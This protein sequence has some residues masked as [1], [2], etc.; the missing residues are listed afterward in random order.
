MC[1]IAGIVSRDGFD[2]QTLIA[3]T[4]MISYR[5]PSG[6]GFAYS[7]HVPESQ[8]EIHYDERLPALNRP[9]IGLG[10]R[11]L[12]ILDLSPSGNQPMQTEDGRYCLTYN[13]EIY[14]YRE[15][16]D[17]LRR[18]G[19]RFNSATDTEVLLRSYAQWGEE[20][21]HRFNGMWSFAL[22]DRAEQTLFCARDR[23]GVKPFY[24]IAKDRQFF[25]ASEIKQ[26]LAAS[27]IERRAN[28]R[29]IADFLEWGLQDHLEETSF[30]GV[31]QL[32]G[33]HSLT[34]HLSGQLRPRIT[35]YWEL[36]VDPELHISRE[37]AVDEFRSRFADAVSLRLR[38]DVPVGVSLSGGLDSSAILCEAKRLS[39]QSTFQA[40]SACFDEPRL[41]ER[42]YISTIL[43]AT[44]SEKHWTFPN[45]QS[46][47]NSLDTI[48]Y[49]QDEPVGGPS[50]F[51]QWRVMQEARANNVP[52]LL[53]GQGG[54]ESLCGYRKYYFFHLWHLLRTANPAFLPESLALARSGTTSHW[55]AGTISR[56]L[57]ATLRKNNSALD[58]LAA[59]ALQTAS[60][61]ARQYIGAARTIAE[62]QKIDLQTTSLPKLLRH[63]DRNSMAHSI[64]SRLPFLDYRLVELAV[65]CP[66]SFK[67]RDGWSKWLLRESLAGTLPDQV[68]LRKSKLG[69]NTPENDWMQQGLRN[70]HREL[71][72]PSKV[73]LH[74]L[75]DPKKMAAECDHFLSG[76]SGNL[77][78]E[79]LF[80]ALSLEMWARVHQVN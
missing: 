33:G 3:M 70:G 72:D 34:L 78:S 14:N 12:A 29:V 13:G 51:A 59:P 48:V 74:R 43:S 57:P 58:R 40:F 69:F 68:R 67:L 30:E 56:Y 8:S 19:H 24:Y 26:V 21:L 28:P 32:L 7:V 46:F 17:E 75:L 66:V 4:Q 42:S 20:C 22:F 54:D 9:V 2:P 35:K 10:N 60:T 16:R 38:S 47:W 37:D 50:V 11:R 77:P 79:T 15:I 41:D 18:L 63:E 1:G 71:C 49:H 64:E 39:P 31:S 6:F 5:G 73:R 80:R 61:N 52:V 44:K 23:F 25:F 53:G 55:S 36:R 62:R 76:A 45:S 27:R 65:R